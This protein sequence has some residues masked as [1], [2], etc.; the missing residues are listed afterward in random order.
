MRLLFDTS[1]LVAAFVEAHPAAWRWLER[2][3]EGAHTGLVDLLPRRIAQSPGL[4][5]S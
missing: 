1:S 3:L 5:S 4:W 2:V